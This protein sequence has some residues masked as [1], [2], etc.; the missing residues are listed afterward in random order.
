MSSRDRKKK[1]KKQ[2][3]KVK[4]GNLQ[5]QQSPGKSTVL[6]AAVLDTSVKQSV[7]C[8]DSKLTERSRFLLALFV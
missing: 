4:S 1:E 5:Q 7:H 8:Q 2:R 3:H 6:R